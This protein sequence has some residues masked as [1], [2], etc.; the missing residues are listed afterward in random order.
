M[1]TK[2]IDLTEK[3]F[4]LCITLRSATVGDNMRKSML[5]A[6]AIS[7]GITDPAEQTVAVIVYPRCVACT[8]EG[9]VDNKLAREM[10]PQEFIALPWE[11][12]EAWLS[13]A[14]ELNPGW[15][16]ENLNND[17]EEAKKKD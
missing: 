1:K 10:T 3:G 4:P 11:V 17:S 8:V 5:T 6:Q 7:S 9:T 15:D 16:L 14:L 2:T 12:G 13:A